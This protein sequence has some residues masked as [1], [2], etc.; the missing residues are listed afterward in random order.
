MGS[1]SGKQKKDMSFLDKCVKAA[2]DWFLYMEAWNTVPPIGYIRGFILKCFGNDKDARKAFHACTRNMVVLAVSTALAITCNPFVVMGGA[3]VAGAAYDLVELLIGLECG[4]TKEDL[5]AQGIPGFCWRI[6]TGLQDGTLTGWDTF[7]EVCFC[8]LTVGFDIFSGWSADKMVNCAKTGLRQFFEAE[9]KNAKQAW[10][11]KKNMF[12]TAMKRLLFGFFKK[13]G[14]ATCLWNWITA[15]ATYWCPP[16]ALI[17]TCME[18][19]GYNKPYY[20]TFD[21]GG[22]VGKFNS[23][24]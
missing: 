12:Q 22:R 13:G 1:S 15:F 5:D 19:P 9:L 3:V 16:L 10:T 11:A 6:Y 2:K 21:Y 18:N 7:V 17:T 8:L 23:R 20:K 4:L 14:P 24:S